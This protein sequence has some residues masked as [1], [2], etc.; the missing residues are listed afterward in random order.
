M[1][2][3][4]SSLVSLSLPLLSMLF[5]TTT[6]TAATTAARRIDARLP[7][8]FPRTTIPTELPA[9]VSASPAEIMKSF[10]T[11]LSTI[12]DPSRHPGPQ[13]TSVLFAF[14]YSLEESVQSWGFVLVPV[15]QA[16][17]AAASKGMF[18]RLLSLTSPNGASSSSAIDSLPIKYLT[19]EN[20][21]RFFP[22]TLG[23]LIKTANLK[24]KFALV[25]RLEA[26]MELDS[27]VGGGYLLIF[28]NE[29][30]HM[31]RGVQTGTS[32]WEA[33]WARAVIYVVNQADE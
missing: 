17:Q 5:S 33:A 22:S 24:Y 31:S 21:T 26:G 11:E 19:S 2:L 15:T 18:S 28:K 13:A 10:E 6:T 20:P 25:A 3:L 32:E 14:S 12:N 23:G 1:Q 8:L 27:V 30:A 7:T 9:L 4:S 29:L 16:P